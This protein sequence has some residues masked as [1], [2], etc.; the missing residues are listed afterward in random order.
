M[1]LAIPGV[2][3]FAATVPQRYPG[4]T[5][6]PFTDAQTAGQNM[7]LSAAGDQAATAKTAF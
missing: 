3:Q 4:T 6:A 5:V 7:A 2:K 1:D